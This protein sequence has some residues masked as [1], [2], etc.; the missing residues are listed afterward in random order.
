MYGFMRQLLVL[1]CDAQEVLVA[2]M[3]VNLNLMYS[4]SPRQKTRAE[5]DSEL[6]NLFKPFITGL[7]IKNICT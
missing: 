1:E 4:H 3:I 7:G 2:K 6:S 5:K